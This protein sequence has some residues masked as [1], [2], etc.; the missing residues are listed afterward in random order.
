VRIDGDEAKI[1]GVVTNVLANAEKFSPPDARISVEIS[2]PKGGR[3]QVAVTDNGR[4]PEDPGAGIEPFKTSSDPRTAGMGIGLTLAREVLKAHGGKIRLG[5]GARG[6][7]RVEFDLPAA[8][9]RSG[10]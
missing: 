8:A 5:R 4:G 1:H 9:G 10:R 7:A 2:P 3:V 6:G